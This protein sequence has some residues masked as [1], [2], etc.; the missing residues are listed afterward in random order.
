MLFNVEVVERDVYD[1]YMEELR[2]RG[3]E[4]ALGLEYNRDQVVD[5][6]TEH[7]ETE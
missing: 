5:I 7:G 6:A 3:N 4:G 2:A 1:A